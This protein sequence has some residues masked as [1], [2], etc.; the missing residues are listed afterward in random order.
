MSFGA[1]VDVLATPFTVTNAPLRVRERERRRERDAGAA[2][3]AVPTVVIVTVSGF[4]AGGSTVS[5]LPAT[6]PVTLA[7]LMFVSPA[8]AAAESVV[9]AVRKLRV[10]QAR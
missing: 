8:F 3:P 6:M 9:C 2:A 10:C 4:D 7:T 1:A 5:V